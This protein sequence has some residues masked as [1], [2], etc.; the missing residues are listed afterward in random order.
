[1]SFFERTKVTIPFWEELM[2]NLT[3]GPALI[4]EMRDVRRFRLRHGADDFPGVRLR[5]HRL[6]PEVDFH[7]ASLK[8]KELRKGVA[9]PI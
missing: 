5:L 2:T 1:M 4:G 8:E 3:P 9:M 6:R 7:S